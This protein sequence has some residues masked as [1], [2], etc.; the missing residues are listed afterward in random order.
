MKYSKKGITV[1]S[2]TIIIIVLLILAGTVTVS[3][4]HIIK[5]T[6]EKEFI[7]EY[8]LIETQ[9]KIML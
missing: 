1:I 5:S 6:Y 9:V 3:T 2:V 8:K 7:R 4:N